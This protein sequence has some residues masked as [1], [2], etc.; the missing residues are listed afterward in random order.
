MRLTHW[1]GWWL[2]SAMCWPMFVD[3]GVAATRDLTIHL[4][5]ANARAEYAFVRARF[6]PGEVPD[7]WAVQFLD[8]QGKTVPYFVWD[9][10]D[11]H[12]AR[13]GRAD[14]GGQYPLLQHHPGNDPRVVGARDEKIRWARENWPDVGRAL[15]E[16]SARAREFPTSVCCA[17]YLLRIPTGPFAKVQLTCRI[18]AS[19]Q[20]QVDRQQFKDRPQDVTVG[21]LTLKGFPLNP[22]VTWRGKPLFRYAGFNA[23]GTE[24][25]LSHVDPARGYEWSLEK[26]LIAKL[27]LRGATAGRLDGV[28]NWQC[29]YWLFPEGAC[30]GLEGF[31]LS[32]TDRYAGGQQEMS[33]WEAAGALEEMSPP[34]W[35]TPWCVHRFG[36]NG[37][38]ATHLFRNTPLTVGYDNNPFI[39]GEA[40]KLGARTE[41]SRLALGWAFDMWSYAGARNFLPDLRSCAARPN[42]KQLSLLAK[43]LRE[44]P[45]EANK[46]EL[47][48]EA[49]AIPASDLSQLLPALATFEWKPRTDWLYRQYAFG[50]GRDRAEAEAAIRHPVC[51]AGGW[52]DRDWRED[53][54]AEL[55]V[56][57]VRHLG[58]LNPVDPAA[59]KRAVGRLDLYPYLL[60]CLATEDHRQMRV[61]AEKASLIEQVHRRIP[62]MEKLIEIGKDPINAGGKKPVVE[63]K[64][65]PA[66]KKGSLELSDEV[67]HRQAAW[68]ANPAYVARGLGDQMRFFQWSGLPYPKDEYE[69]AILKFARFTLKL[70]GGEPFDSERYRARYLQE[71]PSRASMLIPLM[72]EA[73]RLTGEERYAHAARVVFD[74]AFA[75][76]QRNPLGYLDPWSFN[77]QT[78]RPYDTTYNVSGFWRGYGA[79]WQ[80]RQLELIGDKAAKWVAADARWMIVGRLYSDN[81][82]TDSSTYYAT[83]HGGHPGTRVNMFEFLGDDFRFYRG[84]VGEMLRWQLL[85]PERFDGNAYRI[86]SEGGPRKMDAVWME[87]AIGVAGGEH[88]DGKRVY[89]GAKAP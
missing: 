50:L 14:W 79:F 12:T 83:A 30:V 25:K 29:T 70:F 77:P 55:A 5:Q 76:M 31:S 44:H 82:E 52:V 45:A 84:L 65:P 8:R 22:T 75:S 9:S 34:K 81:F 68:I 49:K 13:Q 36:D 28:T 63:G 47:P 51:A 11:W 66:S 61:L 86:P 62:E 67:K 35:E 53:Q 6:E 58:K 69:R 41:G 33:V 7:P 46:G 71:W 26:G 48:P 60:I 43:W 39:T 1:F 40:E 2:V 23:A 42:G 21:Q 15:Q 18:H 38:A 72:L 56:R 10:V 54:L 24:S 78:D 74:D 20:I 37:V 16:Q 19:A 32:R 3:G 57:C 64:A 4:A 80:N 85:A 17:L 87:W 89:R 27:H 73:H 88:W 59:A